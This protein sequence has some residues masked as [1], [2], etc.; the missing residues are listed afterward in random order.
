[1]IDVPFF[2]LL[3]SFGI[4][5]SGFTPALFR[6]KIIREGFSSPFCGHALHQILVRLHKLNF[7]VELACRLL[8]LRHEEQ[9]FNEGKD[10]REF[11]SS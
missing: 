5:V 8:D 10:A 2:S 11:A 7:H 6:S 9:I 4:R 3:F 1:M